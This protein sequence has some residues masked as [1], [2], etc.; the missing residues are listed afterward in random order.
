MRLASRLEVSQTVRF[1]FVLRVMVIQING[2]EN[3]FIGLSFRGRR[4]VGVIAFKARGSLD[5]VEY[6]GAEHMTFK[7]DLSVRVC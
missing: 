6:V 4:V 2:T 3:V 1:C 5:L 7:R